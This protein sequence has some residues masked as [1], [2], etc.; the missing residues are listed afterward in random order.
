MASGGGLSIL[1]LVALL[2]AER[3]WR[4]LGAAFW[5]CRPRGAPPDG[6]GDGAASG[7]TGD[8]MGALTGRLFLSG[9]VAMA[10]ERDVESGERT[11]D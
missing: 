11:P 6:S 8:I 2:S 7:D 4:S 3:D 10:T 5:R 9:V 1:T